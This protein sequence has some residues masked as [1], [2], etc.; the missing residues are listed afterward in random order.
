MSQTLKH[1]PPQVPPGP[2]CTI[3]QADLY[4]DADVDRLSQL[5]DLYARELLDD[6]FGLPD[7]VRRNAIAG[8]REIPGALALLAYLGEKPAG[9]AVCLMSYSTFRAAPVL[10]VHDLMVRREFRGR[11]VANE[12]LRCAE[13]E[14]EKRSCCKVTLEVR[15][16]NQQARRLYHRRGYSGE[17]GADATP[18]TFFL[19]FP[20]L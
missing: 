8:L 7:L 14:A 3:R 17:P 5:H 10:N 2:A 20:L 4:A 6:E 1:L 19:E 18:G 12:L 13:R 11:G 15:E 16:D 9:M